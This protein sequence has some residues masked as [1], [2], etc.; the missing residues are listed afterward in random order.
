MPGRRRPPLRSLSAVGLAAGALAV[1]GAVY[2]GAQSEP[3]LT[4]NVTSF[5]ILRQDTSDSEARHAFVLRKNQRYQFRIH[6]S[7]AGA[8]S[9]RTGHTFAFENVA[10]GERLDVDSRS[11][12]PEGP[13]DYNEYSARVIPSAWQPGVYRL[14]W[15]LRATAVSAASASQEG[16]LVFLVGEPIGP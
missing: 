9:I 1:G 3:A 2:A 12:D 13:G 14:V 11:F 10:T 5:Q 4:L 8:P 6:Y 16:S 7:V 15:T